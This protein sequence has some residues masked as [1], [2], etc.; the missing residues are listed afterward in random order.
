MGGGGPARRPLC[1]GRR[2]CAAG[3][4]VRVRCRPGRLPGARRMAS[5][6]LQLAGLGAVLGAALAAAALLLVR[7]GWGL[8]RPGPR[9]FRR[10]GPGVLRAVALP[11]PLSSCSPAA[12]VPEFLSSASRPLSSWLFLLWRSVPCALRAFH[13]GSPGDAPAHSS[14]AP[15]PHAVPSPTSPDPGRVLGGSPRPAG[16]LGPLGGECSLG[17][18]LRRWLSKQR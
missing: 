1:G 18:P 15:V 11:R 5:L 16:G 14:R 10:R 4:R 3:F 8:T 2:G 9:R 17:P 13:M 7:G 6:P 12:F